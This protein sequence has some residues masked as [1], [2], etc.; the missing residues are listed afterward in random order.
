M[1]NHFL[2]TGIALVI[3]SVS[4]STS[5]ANSADL[6][7]FTDR[8]WD[9]VKDK[10]DNCPDTYNP[11]QDDSDNDGIGDICDTDDCGCKN[12]YQLIY[13]CQDGKSRRVTCSALSES[14]TYCGM[15][16]DQVEQEPD[17][18]ACTPDEDGNI[19]IC[20]VPT[21]PDNMRNLKGTCEELERYFNPDGSFVYP[22]DQCGPCQCS[23]IGDIDSDGDG[24]C[25]GKD[26]CPNN[27]NKDKAGMCGCDDDDSDKDW[28]CDSE[29]ICPGWNDKRDD[30]G[31]GVPNGCDICMGSDDKVDSDNDGVP[32]G[33]DVCPG[34]PDDQDS[35]GDGMMD[36]C[37]VCDQ[38][39]DSVDTDADGVPDACDVCEGFDDAFDTDG[40][41]HPN[42]CDVCEGSDDD[43]DSDGDGIP[44]GCDV[45]SNG[46]DHEDSDGDDI[47]DACDSCEGFDDEF[48]TDGDGIPNGCDVCEGSDDNSDSD[49]DGV[50]DGCDICEGHPDELDSDGD[51]IPNGCDECQ[52]SQ[53]DVDSDGDGVADG[54]D[55]CEGFDDRFDT[56]GD[57]I[58]NGCDVCEG[59]DDHADSDNDGVPDGCDICEG[60]DDRIDSDGDDVPNGCD[61]CEG[62]DDEFDTDGDG[63]PNGCDVCEGSDDKSDDD[64]DGVPNGCD[65]CEGFD[66]NTDSDG[67]DIPNGCDVCE[68]FDDAFDTDGDGIPNG[69]DVCEGSPDD[70]DTDGDGVADGCDVC[71][72]SDDA[73]DA[74]GDDIPDGCDVCQGFD[75][76]FD[77]DGDG[78]PN[79]CDICEGSNDLE[80]SDG[81]GVPNGCDTCSGSDD[82]QDGDGDGVPDGCDTCQNGDDGIDTD[83]DGIPNACDRCEGFDDKIDLDGNGIPDGCEPEVSCCPASGNSLF[84]WIE[85]VKFNDFFNETGD[86]GGYGDYREHKVA[87]TAGDSLDLWVT[88]GFT[89]DICELSV[90]IFIDWNGDMDFDDIGETVFQGRTL[91]ETGTSIVVPHTSVRGNLCMR[92]ILDYGRI[93]GGCD[94]CIDGEVEDYTLSVVDPFCAQVRDN[95]T[96]DNDASLHRQD[97]GQGWVTDWKVTSQNNGKARILQNSLFVNG[98]EYDGGKVGVLNEEGTHIEAT[99]SFAPN[100][101]NSDTWF[102][103]IY[104]QSEGHGEFTFSLGTLQIRTDHSATVSLLGSAS[105]GVEL[106]PDQNHLIVG[107]IDYRPGSEDIYLWIDPETGQKP[108]LKDAMYTKQYLNPVINTVGMSFVSTDA[109]ITEQYVDALHIG[110][111]WEQVMVSSSGESELKRREQEPSFNLLPN[112]ANIGSRVGVEVENASVFRGV[113]SIFDTDGQ[114]VLR[115]NT[116]AGKAQVSTETLIPGVYVIEYKSTHS[117]IREKLVVQN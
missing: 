30:D 21:I 74:D 114:L 45:C 6:S 85:N 106:S 94:P 109:T 71:E 83:G 87:V 75:D 51:G 69:C 44:D 101:P 8:D 99:R 16:E 76:E 28:V 31:D 36:G 113:I 37:D 40:D 91:S 88:P 54:C 33:C 34:F 86:D 53:D 98:L 116:Y 58:P 82:S 13:V 39:D 48:D 64:G 66:D 41:G 38:G 20:H 92:V 60:S 96:Y 50:P 63:I 11:W 49:A 4:I 19:I 104:N 25:D 70:T 26:E 107:F 115:E 35:D 102:S 57:G 7:L 14:N 55:I 29:D 52:G 17:C 42:G 100:S 112:P 73:A 117:L 67:D 105:N 2:L 78:I 61:I 15:C 79:G 62:F 89:D 77:T 46:D 111:S 72:G 43:A 1:K 18:S 80:D 10:D 95:F 97:G 47:P 32:D 5:H 108:D 23:F 22:L 3:L 68:G 27:P 103:Y 90:G 93:Y 9:G 56:D 12:E 65:I 84:E 59:S 81:D 110:C 24:V